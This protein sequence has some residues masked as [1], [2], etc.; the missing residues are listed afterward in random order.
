MLIT[1]KINEASHWSYIVK[2]I[3][4]TKMFIF[5]NNIKVRL[6]NFGHMLAVIGIILY[7]KL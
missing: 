7:I 4:K 3:T 1:I 2:I 6:L 5:E